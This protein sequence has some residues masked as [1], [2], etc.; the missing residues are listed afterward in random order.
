MKLVLL[1]VATLAFTACQK[2]DLSEVRGIP[3]EEYGN[4]N[5][6]TDMPE[7][8]GEAGESHSE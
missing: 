5:V 3:R 2:I 8:G 7:G 1:L 4:G 6:G